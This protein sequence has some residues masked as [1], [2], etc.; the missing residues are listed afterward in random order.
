[1]SDCSLD[2]LHISARTLSSLSVASTLY[3]SFPLHLGQHNSI[4]S[5][6]LS[7]NSF[8]SLPWYLSAHIIGSSRFLQVQHV[9]P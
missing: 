4:F 9:S 5:F 3:S 2:H 8:F 1:M 7:I 6:C